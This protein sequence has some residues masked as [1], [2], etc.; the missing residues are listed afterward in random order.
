MEFAWD[1]EPGI[2]DLI[3]LAE[4]VLFCTRRMSRILGGDSITQAAA[5]LV[6]RNVNFLRGRLRRPA[7]GPD[8][9]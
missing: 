2:W 8:F 4:P 5:T 3:L 1:L 6:A 7:R 9:S